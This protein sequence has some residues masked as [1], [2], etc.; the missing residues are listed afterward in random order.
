M[1]KWLLD[2]DYCVSSLIEFSSSILGQNQVEF[3]PSAPVYI[4]LYFESV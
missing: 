2:K 1:W 4:A 3:P